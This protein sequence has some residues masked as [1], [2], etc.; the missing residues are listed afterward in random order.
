MREL[1]STNDVLY[2]ESVRIALDA[3]HIR[4]VVSDAPLYRAGGGGVSS[5]TV[6]VLHNA[7]FE[8]ARAVLK[9]VIHSSPP[10]ISYED[11]R[12][13]LRVVTYAVI[14]ALLIAAIWYWRTR[15]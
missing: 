15:S 12:G 8:R 3:H 10:P 4:A 1:T 11:V 6:S 9:E 2:A 13:G 5:I 7:D 14:T